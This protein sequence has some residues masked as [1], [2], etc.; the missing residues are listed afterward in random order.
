MIHVFRELDLAGLCLLGLGLGLTLV[1][2]TIVRGSDSRWDNL[3]VIVCLSFGFSLLMGFAYWETQA[4]HP[5]MPYH[6]SAHIP[7]SNYSLTLA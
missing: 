7:Y 4:S 6:V 5:M 2:L 1:P 3:S